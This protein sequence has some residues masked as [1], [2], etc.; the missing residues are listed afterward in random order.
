MQQVKAMTMTAEKQ[1]MEMKTNNIKNTAVVFA[2]SA[3]SSTRN[4]GIYRQYIRKDE[5]SRWAK[6]MYAKP[7]SFRCSRSK[8]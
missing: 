3:L 7:C 2:K 5:L 6:A 1:T 4:W 8:A